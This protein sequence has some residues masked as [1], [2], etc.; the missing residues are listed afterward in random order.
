[1]QRAAW[2]LLAVPALY[3]GAAGAAQPQPGLDYF[4]LQIASGDARGLETLYARYASLPHLRIERRGNTCTLRAGFWTN[5]RDARA[6]AAGIAPAQPMIRAAMYRPEEIVRDNWRTQA[7]A[8]DGMRSAVASTLPL[9][10]V[11]SYPRVPGFVATLFVPQE[12]SN[13]P[14]TLWQAKEAAPTQV[15]L[16]PPGLSPSVPAA[17][18]A[19]PVPAAADTMADVHANSTQ[20]NAPPVAAARAEPALVLAA[21]SQLLVVP[22]DSD[23]GNTALTR[24]PVAPVPVERGSTSLAALTQSPGMPA[25]PA[26]ATG[27]TN[28]AGAPARKPNVPVLDEREE[29][30]PFNQEDYVLAYDIFVGAGDLRRGYRVAEKAVASVP[31][32]AEWRLKLARVAEWTQRPGVAW[33]QRE[34]LFRRGDRGNDTLSALLRLAPVAPNLDTVLA[35]WEYKAARGPLSNQQWNDIAQMFDAAARPREGSRFF[36]AQ[37]RRHHDVELLTRAAQLAD[38]AGDD[39]RAYRLYNERLALKPFTVDLALRARWCSCCARTAPARP[40]R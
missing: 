18:S 27:S 24:P 34:W 32:D 39:E 10:D 2:S 30:L 3:A 25:P 19:D 29:L 28:N 12:A 7:R 37:Y 8:R 23:T 20:E 14:A 4:S 16:A 26:P 5:A 13:A 31:E 22:L 38:N 40:T 17:D 36:E 21:S 9:T 11:P 35:V 15:A 33:A 6:A 1:M